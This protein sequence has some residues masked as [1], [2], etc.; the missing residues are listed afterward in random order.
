MTIHSDA[1]KGNKEGVAAAIAQGVD[2]NEPGNSN[3]SPLHYASIG[4]FSEIVAML[5]S[6]GASVNSVTSRGATPLHY[7]SRSGRIECVALLLEN[8]ADVDCRD[9]SENTPLHTAI[10]YNCNEVKTALALINNYNADV[11]IQ[12]KEGYTPLHLASQ[13]G[14]LFIPVVIA[15]IEKGAKID[16]RDL[17]GDTAFSSIPLN[18]EE[19]DHMNLD[20]NNDDDDKEK[21]KD[22]ADH[23]KSNGDGDT[24]SIGIEKSELRKFSDLTFSVDNR[25]ILAHKCI[26][27]VR[28]QK[29]FNLIVNKQSNDKEIEKESTNDTTTSTTTTTTT[30]TTTKRTIIEIKDTSFQLFLAIIEWIYKNR[31][32]ELVK[33]PDPLDLTF[34]V[35]LLQASERYNIKPLMSQCE[36]YIAQNLNSTNM[37]TIW[38]EFKK[39]ATLRSLFPQ[40]ST[41]CAHI[42]IKNWN[43]LDVTKSVTEMSRQELVEMIKLLSV[44]NIDTSQL[45][46][47]V[48]GGSNSTSNKPTAQSRPSTSVSSASKPG[49]PQPSTTTPTK[50]APP[51]SVS[52]PASAKKETN[53]GSSDSL[54]DP[55]N[56]SACKSILSEIFKKRNSFPFHKPVDPLVEG[57]PDY[58]D[59]IKNPMD[60]STIQ[61]KLENGQYKTVKD[62]ANDFRLMFQNAMTFNADSSP[63]FKAAK[64][65]LQNF[66]KLFQKYF[67]NEKPVVYKPLP[68][69][70]S[71]SPQQPTTPQK[72]STIP[73]TPSTP[74]SSKKR[75]TMDSL[76]SP[77][78]A[79][80]VE[81]EDQV[82]TSS[83]QS[84]SSS[85]ANTN[86]ST[87]PSSSSSSSANAQSSSSKKYSDEERKSLMDKINILDENQVDEILQI[88]DEKA[89][90]YVG[91]S[92]EIDMYEIDDKNLIEIENF[93]NRCLGQS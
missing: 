81:K 76:S 52:T 25:K 48:S 44:Q 43:V 14:S 21:N 66:D 47:R 7:A 30:T 60:L 23:S 31:V 12:N 70:N 85:S 91:D 49:A 83:S 77:V 58:F 90:K 75:K 26:V 56:S 78:K 87:S 50:T 24:S 37:G 92:T 86:Q 62:Y 64:S 40:L 33:K 84:T 29:L 73:Q 89:I 63:V 9:S 88:I 1:E 74:E 34:A 36:Y 4:G 16:I 10:I 80:A 93:L 6:K 19:V 55:K 42:L 82:V 32:D 15:L 35:S 69:L 67:P 18:G 13:R 51:T 28:C 59:I 45:P 57:I 2:V 65:L 5:L 53:G 20:D 22:D 71:S 54:S 79:T 27:S 61:N 8:G 17:K 11:N 41:Y 46:T 38:P 3:R 68:S 72:P 39:S